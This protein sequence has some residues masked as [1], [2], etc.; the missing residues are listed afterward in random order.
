[1]DRP[2]KI[3]IVLSM[4]YIFLLIFIPGCVLITEPTTLPATVTPTPDAIIVPDTATPE[5]PIVTATV[6]FLD[7]PETE[8]TPEITETTLPTNTYTTEP[9]K[10]STS[11]P[12]PTPYPYAL[13]TGSPAYIENYAYPEAGCNWVGVAGQVFG[14]DGA[15]Q[16]NLVV[17]VKGWYGGKKNEIAVL[18]GTVQG[19]V[20]GPGGYEALVGDTPQ[21]TQ[22]QL[23]IQVFDLDGNPLTS[24]TKFDTY[25][26]CD[27]NLIII[28]FSQ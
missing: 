23:S 14:S 13:Q 19:D 22:K 9:A 21:A 20:Y 2:F 7:T 25:N 5:K 17:I 11:T 24:E 8:V 12:S 26:A 16:T 10:T 28:N 15:P 1:M 18:T 3:E 4:I 27:K 6:S